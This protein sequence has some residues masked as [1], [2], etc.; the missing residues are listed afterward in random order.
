[1]SINSLLTNQPILGALKVAIGGGGGGGGAGATGPQGAT[2]PSGA[3]TG[4]T[5]TLPVISSAGAAPVISL[6]ASGVTAATIP[7]GATGPGNLASITIDTYGR[8]TAT[9]LY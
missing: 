1:M 4:V 9:T 5:A 2:G 6:S 8:I 7:V 3:V